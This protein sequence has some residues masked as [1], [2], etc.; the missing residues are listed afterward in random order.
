MAKVSAADLAVLFWHNKTLSVKNSEVKFDIRKQTYI[1]DV[2]N[3][4]IGLKTNNTDVKA[5]YDENDLSAVHLFTLK[6]EY[7][8]EC[9]Q[10]TL[11]VKAQVNQTEADVLNIVKQSRHNE[12]MVNTAKRLTEKV[13]SDGLK[14]DE[15]LLT[16]LDPFTTHKDLYNSAESKYNMDYIYNEKSIDGSKVVDY[17]PTDPN[18]YLKSKLTKTTVQERHAKKNIVPASL[19]VIK[20]P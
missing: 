10:K 18:N 19:E 14:S 17:K 8:C 16:T 1:Y 4:E 7:I 6:G 3:H 20:R 11:I 12:S 13:I 2:F 5:Y 9:R 15:G